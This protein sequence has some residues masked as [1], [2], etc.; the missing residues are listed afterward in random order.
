[1]ARSTWSPAHAN[2]LGEII[3]ELDERLSAID[4]KRSIALDAPPPVL[5]G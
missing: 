3:G 5:N 2:K 4:G 1:V